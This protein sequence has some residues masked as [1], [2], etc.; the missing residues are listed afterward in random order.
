METLLVI[1]TSKLRANIPPYKITEHFY[2]L[3]ILVPVSYIV[4]NAAETTLGWGL[5]RLYLPAL[6]PVASWRSPQQH[7]ASTVGTNIT[8]RF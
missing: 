5:S 4:C 8:F 6:E 2:K 3:G 7:P 1:R